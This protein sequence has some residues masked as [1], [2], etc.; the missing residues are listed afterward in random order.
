MYDLIQGADAFYVV[1]AQCTFGRSVHDMVHV[2]GKN[3]GLDVDTCPFFIAAKEGLSHRDR[4]DG[5]T[6]RVFEHFIDGE[7]D[8][9]DRDGPFWGDEGDKCGINGYDDIKAVAVI[10]DRFYRTDRVDMT[11]NNV[12]LKSVSH[13]HSRFDVD[14][15]LELFDSDM[16]ERFG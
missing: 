2:A 6:K 3:V 5:K 15:T 16:G 10:G 14:M 13:H 12:P 1:P 9:I 7:T 8:A 11:L 4:D